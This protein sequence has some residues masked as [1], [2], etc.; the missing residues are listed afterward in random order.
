M[1]G[2]T[3]INIGN[4]ATAFK[5]SYGKSFSRLFLVYPAII[6]VI[7]LFLVQGSYDKV[8]I[9][10]NGFLTSFIPIFATIFSIYTSWAF[11]AAK[12]RHAADR[13]QLIE[14]TCAAILFLIPL[15]LFAL[16]LSV[17]SSI[18]VG[19]HIELFNIEIDYIIKYSQTFNL[20]ILLKIISHYI[21]YFLLVDI[22]F[23]TL[24]IV[25]RSYILLTNEIVLLK[26]TPTT[27]TDAQFEQYY[28]IAVREIVKDYPVDAQKV[29]TDELQNMK[30]EIYSEIEDAT[31][32]EA[33][34][35]YLFVSM[36]K[37]QLLLRK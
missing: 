19:E 5:A 33:F 35:S 3:Y 26:D 27:I 7:L 25:K 4:L 24:T 14:E 2:F 31:K 12:S 10:T 6:A 9:V 21:Y 23:V 15:D 36:I 20:A 17:L 8:I 34:S 32:D 37:Q 28:E 29:K 13:Y 22:A 16:V 18:T 1:K 11:T 30:Q